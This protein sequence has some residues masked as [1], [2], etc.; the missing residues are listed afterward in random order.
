MRR[1]RP[2]ARRRR[3]ASNRRS[4]SPP[5]CSNTRHSGRAETARISSAAIAAGECAIRAQYENARAVV[6][7]RIQRG[8]RPADERHHRHI[9]QRPA[10]TRG[11]KRQRRRRR[12]HAQFADGQLRAQASRPRRTASDRRSPARIPRPPRCASTGQRR[13]AAAT[14]SRRAPIR[15]GQHRQMT[16]A[17]HDDRTRQATPA[18]RRAPDRQSR[19]RRCPPRSAMPASHPSSFCVFK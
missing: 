11:R 4:R 19:L 6:Q 2:L 18:A 16:L 9:L 14:R 17:A 1:R 13:T 3:G 8:E 12:Q 10:K 15:R 5:R 7:M